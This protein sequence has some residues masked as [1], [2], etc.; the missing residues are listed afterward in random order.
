MN[1]FKSINVLEIFFL[2][3]L[4]VTLL[5]FMKILYKIFIPVCVVVL[6]QS[7]VFV[8]KE[9]LIREPYLQ[10]VWADSATVSW[11]S[12]MEI[13]NLKLYYGTQKNNLNQ[14]A[15]VSCKNHQGVKL[16]EAVAKDLKPDTKYYYQIKA[17]DEVVV[18]GNDYYFISAPIKQRKFTFYAMGDIGANHGS[19]AGN[20]A[21][22]IHKLSERPDFGLGLGDIVYPKGE[23]EMYDVNLFDPL[24][25][26]FKNIPFYPCL[27]NH[28]WYV[29]KQKGSYNVSV[30]D[31]NFGQ[32]FK[33]PNN[34]HYYGFEY[35]NTYFIALD[36]RDGNFY[37]ID[38]QTVWLKERLER[39][40]GKYD[41]VVV[42]L[43]HNGKTCSYKPDYKHVMKLYDVF[44]K[45]NVDLVLNGHAHTYERLKPYD[46]DG[47]VIKTKNLNHFSKLKHG[48]IS[49]TTGAGGK[50][51][52]KWEPNV[53]NAKNCI[54]GDIVAAYGH[55]PHFSLFEIDGKK[56]KMKAINSLNGD[57]FDEFMMSK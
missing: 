19:Y 3:L 6:V 10:A 57:V 53:S 49:I 33:L 45:G 20:S 46:K 9:K 38:N 13:T 16:V 40:K 37:D 32:E 15:I 4:N 39:I 8:K 51:N 17:S 30:V 31:H 7:F 11:K 14:Q 36:S 50:L 27:G 48:F 21:E 29:A 22:Q 12:P 41:W 25:E 28:D 42:Y 44:A 2:I 52:S 18:K 34:E 24:K 35:L 54:D 43:H 55:V 56:L 5:F 47:H 26:V 1:Y 23:S